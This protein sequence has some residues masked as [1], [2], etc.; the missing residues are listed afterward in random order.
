MDAALASQ[1]ASIAL[2]H[3][4]REYPNRLD[5]VLTGP[6]DL[7]SPRALHPVF[8][9]SFD[10]HSCVHSYW[11]L[12][13]LL[14]VHPEIPESAAIREIFDHALTPQNIAG[15]C[16]YLAQPSS[17][18]FERPYGWAWLLE[19]QS[20]LLRHNSNWAGGLEPLAVA[21]VT[22]FRQWLPRAT[23]PVRAGTHGNTAFALRLACDYANAAQDEGFRLIL[24]AAAR[25]W[26][27]NDANCQCR[28]PGGEDFLSP[29]LVEAQCMGV[30]LA[31]DEFR[32]WFH[33]FLPRLRQGEP[34]CLF[35]PAIVS[36]RSDG[37]IVHLDGLN[38]SR[39]W[40]WFE[41]AGLLA[42]DDRVR[43]L[44][45]DTAEHHL[46]AA[47]PSITGHYMGEHW[48]ATYALLAVSARVQRQS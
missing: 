41:I 17:A 7:Q 45:I 27:A 47:L 31:R 16:A 34:H 38:L 30:V 36:D 32:D 6:E 25:R 5:H 21:F 24:H 22:R 1:M 10:W 2:S 40:S 26:Y 13:T 15:E 28:E 37:R 23:Y 33:K 44:A 35:Q 3:I 46:S 11:L 39:A 42:P 43:R 14:R 48:L 29:S 19:L 12:A 9:G 18:G 8:Y 20:E 4:R